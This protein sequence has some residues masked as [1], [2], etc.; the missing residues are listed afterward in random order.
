[1]SIRQDPDLNPYRRVFA[2]ILF[3]TALA[4]AI[5]TWSTSTGC[6]G[7][8]FRHM[9]VKLDGQHVVIPDG[10]A[11]QYYRLRMQPVMPLFGVDSYHWFAR[12]QYTPDY[13]PHPCA[14]LTG[15]FVRWCWDNGYPD[16]Y[17]PI[18]KREGQT[19]T[20][21]QAVVQIAG[22]PV[23]FDLTDGSIKG[24]GPKDWAHHRD[25]LPIEIKTNITWQ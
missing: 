6:A 16:A 23:H 14:R 2:V 18:Y 3:L 20:H 10:L 11:K 25:A 22:R 9:S 13:G 4:G 15:R 1:M 21:T 8:N 7:V 24:C 17:A 12:R 5:V 19:R